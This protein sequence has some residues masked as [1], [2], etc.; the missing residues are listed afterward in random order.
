MAI[1]ENKTGPEMNDLLHQ[2]AEPFD[3]SEIKWRV[4]HT[5]RDGSRGAVIAFADPRAYTDRLNQLFTPSGW[6]RNYDVTTVSAI[7]RVKRDKLI[8]TGKVLVTC[9]LTIAR[10]GCHS[11]SGEEW[12]DEEN[13]FTAAEAQAFKRTAMC[14]GLGRYLYK[15]PET[16]VQ[17]DEYRKPT[18]LPALPQWALPN[19]K[20]N[21][22]GGPRAAALQR[23]PIDQETMAR[24]EGFQRVLGDS[25]YGEILWRV[26][27]T[28]RANAIANAQLQAAVAEAMERASRGIHK[29]RSLAESIGDTQFVSLLDR[30]HIPSMSAIPN[31]EVLKQLVAQLEEMAARSAA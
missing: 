19:G 15:L 6:T 31:L 24:I 17:L 25:I 9:T 7:S 23:G 29:T 10:L 28:R 12:A 5:N 4:T 22:A 3:L 26:A 20:A 18:R 27:R 16:W 11:G 14:F 21:P 1:E 2:L 30:L 13:A 8:Q